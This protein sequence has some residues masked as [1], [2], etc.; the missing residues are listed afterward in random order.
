MEGSE[1]GRQH[2]S[3][4]ALREGGV[5][6][7][8]DTSLDKLEPSSASSLPA[9]FPGFPPRGHSLSSCRPSRRGHLFKE[10]TLGTL[11]SPPHPPPPLPILFLILSNTDGSGGSS[12]SVL[13]TRR[14]GAMSGACR[15]H[16][17]PRRPRGE[18]PY[19]TAALGGGRSGA[20]SPASRG[21]DGPP[22]LSRPGSCSLAPGE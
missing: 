4:S 9:C 1:L 14:A 8:R 20:R 7:S 13:P 6:R 15:V 18:S 12:W 3:V 11:F 2:S 17:G 22:D 5:P 19:G 16:C 10:A 21:Q